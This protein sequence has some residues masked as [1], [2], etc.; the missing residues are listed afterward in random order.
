LSSAEKSNEKNS[1]N[2]QFALS[3]AKI[4]HKK[5]TDELKINERVLNKSFGS[6]Q[7]Q[8]NPQINVDIGQNM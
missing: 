7:E 1:Y 5:L 3:F 6:T 2:Y 8:K 4:C